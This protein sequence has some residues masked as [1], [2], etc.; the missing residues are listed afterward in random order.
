MQH[1]F[2]NNIVNYLCCELTYGWGMQGVC[3]WIT[4][5]IPN[6]RD[7]TLLQ[8][9]FINSIENEAHFMLD[10]PLLI[11]SRRDRFPSLLRNAVLGSL[12]YFFQWDHQVNTNRYLTEAVAL[13]YSRELACSTPSWCTFS[14]SI[15]PFAFPGL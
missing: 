9:C 5:T 3:G 2:I 12:T 15:S 11:D 6:S 4:L 10:C 7:S 8:L 13:R 14:S 1:G